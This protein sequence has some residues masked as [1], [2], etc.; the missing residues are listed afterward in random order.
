M[1]LKITVPRPLMPLPEFEK[2]T[3][4]LAIIDKCILTAT[5]DQRN[6]LQNLRCRIAAAKDHIEM[7]NRFNDPQWKELPDVMQSWA[8]NFTHCVTDI[9]SLGNSVKSN[10]RFHDT[11]QM[12]VQEDIDSN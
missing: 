12:R 3:A 4:Q 2:A 11:L 7:N 1:Q 5:P 10:N 9:S 8:R 6:R